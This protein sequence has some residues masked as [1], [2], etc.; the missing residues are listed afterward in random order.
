MQARTSTHPAMLVP[1]AMQALLRFGETA[2]DLGV[3]HSTL[4]LASLRASQI[5]GCSLCVH[6]HAQTLRKAG[7][8]DERIDTVAA[9]RESPWFTDEERAALALAE[10]VTRIADRPDPVPDEVWDEVVDCFSEAEV[11]ALVLAIAT[12][13]VW[14]RL[15]A[16]TRQPAGALPG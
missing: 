15:N 9:W 10:C 16:A 6:L 12:T 14:N 1:G 5:N 11:A 2:K 13:N 4:E 8:S 3:D 7:E